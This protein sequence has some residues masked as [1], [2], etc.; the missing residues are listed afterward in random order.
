MQ[1]NAARWLSR[2][3]DKLPNAAGL[4]LV[5]LCGFLLARLLWSGWQLGQPALL[6][7]GDGTATN[8]PA[9]TVA[10]SLGDKLASLHL[11]GQYQ[12][13]GSQP[14]SA[15]VQPTQLALKLQGVYV[16]ARGAAFAVIEENG[17]QKA[18]GVGDPLGSSGAILEQVYAD[19]VLLRRN[20]VLEKLQLPET[21]LSGSANGAAD[22]P[23]GLPIDTTS[24]PLDMLPPPDSFM[25]NVGEGSA[26]PPINNEAVADAIPI[27]GTS[28]DSTPTDLG[29]FRQ[30]VMQN[31]ARLL[32]V[33]SPQ[34]Y[35]REG[36]FLGF[37]LSPGSNVALFNQL[38]LQ[39][40]DIVTSIN[41]MPLENPA[42]AMQALQGAAN[43][44][45][46]TLGITR[47]GQQLSLPV[48]LQ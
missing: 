46:V 38:G 40:G 20:G 32:E 9:A 30:S 24:P 27:P 13:D 22:M 21:R 7:T 44:P 41:G 15:N 16:P 12:P 19:H 42:A 34:P 6:A 3:T 29:A 17:E 8:P 11:F 1:A 45:Q 18:Y 14:A 26:P 37:Q 31:H 2:W 48:N 47:G 25:P 35:E 23:M 33:V 4:G 36:K 5:V 43:A 10:Q 39:A 28:V